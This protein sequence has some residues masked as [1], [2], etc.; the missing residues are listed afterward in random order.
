[1]ITGN[2]RE[3][4]AKACWGEAIPLLTNSG[5]A[6]RSAR[7]YFGR[8]LSQHHLHPSELLKAVRS[9]ESMGT[10]DPASYLNK[11]AQGLSLARNDPSLSCSWS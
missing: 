6:E 4:Q 8:L 1:M 3:A 5:M 2:E 11:A 7:M 9:A 10:G